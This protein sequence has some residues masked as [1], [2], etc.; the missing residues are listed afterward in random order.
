ML[1]FLH[2]APQ[3]RLVKQRLNLLNKLITRVNNALKATDTTEQVDESAKTLVRKIQGTRATAKKT[4][5]DKAAEKP[6]EKKPKEIS[7]SN[8]LRQSFRQ[9]RQTH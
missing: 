1:H 7:S 6:Q 3:L 2:T 4:D 5:E 9:L 8:E